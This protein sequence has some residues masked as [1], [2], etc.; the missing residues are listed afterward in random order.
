MRLILT[1]F[2]VFIFLLGSA[3]I[4]AAYAQSFKFELANP[5]QTINSGSTFQVKILINTGGVE[6]I[7][8][9]ALFTFDPAKVSM[10]SATT[11]NFYSYFAANPLGGSTTKYLV[12]SWEESVAH[13]KS[14]STD[15]L[16][17]TLSLTAKACGT[18]QLSFDCTNGTEAD[19]NINRASDSKDI[20]TCPLAPLNI[21]L[22]G[23]DT[24]GTPTPTLAASPTSTPSATPT[25]RPTNTPAPTATPG[26]IVTQMPRA[27]SV[28]ITI[29]ALGIGTLLTVVGIL[30]IL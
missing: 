30:F 23:A 18:T 27:G 6:T 20:I 10:D 17:A 14:T 15:V 12:S 7:N 28:E 25:T 3:S 11:G 19:S 26:P 5:E 22:C 2:I 4:H 29:A 16:F 13:A 8:G 1:I 21:S 24:G 9:D